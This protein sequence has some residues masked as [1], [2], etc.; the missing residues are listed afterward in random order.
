MVIWSGQK[1]VKLCLVLLN[2]RMPAAGAVPGAERKCQKA[3][4]VSDWRW[5]WW[6]ESSKWPRGTWHLFLNGRLA[7]KLVNRCKCNDWNRLAKGCFGLLRGC[8]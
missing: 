1:A 8:P 6:I 3:V 2:F 7:G 5:I 4:L